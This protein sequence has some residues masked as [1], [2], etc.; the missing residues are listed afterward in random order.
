MLRRKIKAGMG[1]KV[2]VLI[3]MASVVLGGEMSLSLEGSE[4]MSRAHGRTI[5]IPGGGNS[6]CKGAK[7]G[8]RQASSRKS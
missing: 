7:A 6:K 2:A 8:A 5:S 3:G 1:G 4:G